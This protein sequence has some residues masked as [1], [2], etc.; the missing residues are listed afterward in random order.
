MAE[1]SS[2]P[3]AQRQLNVAGVV[4]SDNPELSNYMLASNPDR[5]VEVLKSAFARV[6]T[7]TGSAG[8]GAL[9]AA[10]LA[11]GETGVFVPYYDA[12]SWSGEVES[13]RFVLDPVT[14]AVSLAA[15]PAWRASERVPPAAERRILVGSPDAG[16]RD[17][18]WRSRTP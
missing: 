17:F 1:T 11:A 15:R 14:R 18:P 3:I 7:T 6:A 5:M 4:G 8:G 10:T 2:T 13:Y 16:A 9:T 12:A